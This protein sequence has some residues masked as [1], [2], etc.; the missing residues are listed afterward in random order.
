MTKLSFLR[1]P[2]KLILFVLLMVLTTTAALVFCL[3]YVL[4]GLVMAHSMNSTAYVGSVYSRVQE[5][6]MLKDIPA[7]ILQQLETSSTVD[8]VMAAPVYS[9]RAEGLTRVT[10]GFG[11][12]ESLNMKLFLEG[13]VDS[14]PALSHSGFG[15]MET[16]ILKITANWGGIW[17]GGA[18]ET[19]I[20]RDAAT[21]APVLKEGDHVFLVGRYNSN[22]N[23]DVNGMLLFDPEMLS[24]LGL[25]TD[26]ALWTH[27]ILVLPDDLSEEGSA[28]LIRSFLLESGLEESRAL[29]AQITDMFTVH[30]VEDMSMLLTVA[31]GTTFITEGR[32]LRASDIGSRVCV[33]NEAVARQ[34][35]LSLGDTIRLSI[36][37]GCYTYAGDFEEYRGWDNGYPYEGDELLEY[38]AYEAFEIVGLYSEINRIAG[39]ADYLHHTRNDIFIP[40]GLLPESDAAVRSRTVTFRVLGPNY[41]DFM[42][43]F[44]VSLNEQGYTLSM[45]DTGW[46]AMSGSF[47]AMS[48]RR[49]LM[50]ACGVVAFIAA[51]LSFDVLLSG[52]FRYEFGLR[53]L[54]GAHSG[55]ARE[56]YISG[57]LVTAIPAGLM[58]VGCSFGVYCLLLKGQAAASLP[59]ALPGDGQI[60]A[61]LA[62]WTAAELIG[63]FAVLMVISVGIHRQSLLRLLK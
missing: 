7:N 43:E 59:V 40:G 3:Q 12:K 8:A 51:I 30:E 32:E 46:A 18:I 20:F 50:L 13:T 5:Y 60:L 53:R 36:S 10:D 28:P 2:F 63:A 48:D 14:R 54:L 42:N 47:Y 27:A 38:G 45:V 16:F 22:A 25:K 29:M 35:G 34:N 52:H 17:P 19:C 58:A 62:L 23:G 11:N 1:K 24:P 61:Y 37:H 4:D 57:F 31:D 21:D 9:A 56:I 33:I 49:T 6:P 26:S 15:M 55:E 39:S 41:E 44:E